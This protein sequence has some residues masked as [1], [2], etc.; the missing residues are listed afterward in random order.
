M[1]RRAGMDE[2]NAKWCR[3]NKRYRS[4]YALGR[5]AL[6]FLEEFEKKLKNYEEFGKIFDHLPRFH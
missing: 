5:G 6:S 4:N 1:Y 3:P 2:E